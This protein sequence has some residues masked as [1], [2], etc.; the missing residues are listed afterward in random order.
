MI[1]FPHIDV[2]D[3]LLVIVAE[4]TAC[5]DD[6]ALLLR[7]FAYAEDLTMLHS[8][9]NWK[10][11]EGI[12]SQDISTLLAYLQPWRLKLS[13]TE[14]VMAA[15]HFN[16]QEAKCELKAYNNDRLLPFY[17]TRIYL[18]VKLD[19]SLMFCH[20][21]VALCKKLSLRVTLLR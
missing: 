6:L 16:N 8:S 13:H 7:K 20:H 4:I 21:L 1:T 18:W 3:F 19:R 12:L 17:P 11:L 10:D 9:G 5:A 15:F 2:I 14:T